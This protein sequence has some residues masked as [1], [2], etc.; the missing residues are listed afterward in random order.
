[1]LRG[2]SVFMS[3]KKISIVVT[4]EPTYIKSLINTISYGPDELVK[5]SYQHPESE[6]MQ[7]VQMYFGSLQV[8]DN[9]RIDFFGGNEDGLFDF[10]K[11][12]P[13]NSFNGLILILNAEEADRVDGIKTAFIKHQNYLSK[14]TLVVA[15]SGK[16]Y[17]KIKQAEEHVRKTLSDLDWV[18][19]VFSIDTENKEDVS[20]LVESL[21]CSARPGI[22]D[23]SH[24]KSLFEA[25][26]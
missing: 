25:G 7:T 10:V 19:P 18:A 24:G 23:N 11:S 2:V 16:D 21:L 22:N 1:M 15:V 8:D 17:K 12:R 14:H 3:I 13:Q 5:H 4:G 26:E 6:S 20:L 9:H